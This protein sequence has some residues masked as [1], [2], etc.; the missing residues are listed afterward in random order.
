MATPA[1]SIPNHPNGWISLALPGQDV[2]SNGLNALTDGLVLFRPRP[3]S[4][5]VDGSYY[6]DIE[7]NDIQRGEWKAICRF[8]IRVTAI[9]RYTV[10]RVGAAPDSP[11][12]FVEGS[13]LALGEVRSMRHREKM[14]FQWGTRPNKLEYPFEFRQ[15][16]T[17]VL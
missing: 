4:R 13:E 1:P 10:E 5:E 12:I 8:R 14:S 3:I 6:C 15:V 17:A 9:I 11:R 7:W 16:T 2:F